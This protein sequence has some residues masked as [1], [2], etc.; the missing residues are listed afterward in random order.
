MIRFGILGAGNIAHRFASSLA[1]EEGAVLAA[2]AR[3]AEEKAAAFLAEV[4]H[5]D[6]ARAYGGF[7][8]LLEDPNIDAVYL[9]LPHA[10]HHEWAIKTLRAGKA[11][12]CEKPATLSEAEMT[13]VA[14]VARE[15]GA[16]F[17][18]AMKTRFVPIYQQIVAAVEEIGPIVRVEALLCND[19]LSHAAGRD[20]YH[21]HG[22]AG[23]GA[24]LDCGIYCASWLE[25]FLPGG[26]VL[27]DV[28]SALREGV[29]VYVNAELSAG[30]ATGRL[31]CAFDRS[32]PR[33]A[34]IE[35]ERGRIVVD[36]LHRPT[37]A[38][39]TLADGSRRELNAAYAVDD[40]YGEIHHFCEL[41]RTGAT[42]SPIMPL[43]ASIACA[44][45]LDLVRGGVA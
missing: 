45:I 34:I 35:G 7:D 41:L 13:E 4:L 17:M 22:G 18:E 15:T 12:L 36:E 42:E 8:L 32:K 30:G 33:Q 28:D 44:R 9:S 29:D 43:D 40:F 5:A 23:A 10:F 31:E 26:L 25:A 3:R 21:L 39:L 20:S 38:V 24:L 19:M 37:H 6:D 1:H 11:V 16:L 2:A 14:A 27:N